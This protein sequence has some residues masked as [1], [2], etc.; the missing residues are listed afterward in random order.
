MKPLVSVI[1]PVYNT[2]RY[3]DKCIESVLA[4]TVQ[5]LEIILVDDGATDNSPRLCDEWAKKES[6]IQVIHKQNEGLGYTRNA[7][8]KVAMGEYVSFLD[9]DDT[10]DRDTYEK[11]IRRM[12]ELGADACYFGRKTMDAQGNMHLNTNIPEQLV[13][14]GRDVSAEFAKR[15]FGYFPIEESK[16]PYIQASACC[17]LYRRGIIE[18]NGL[19]FCSEREYLSEDSFFN[20]DF[21]KN[22]SCVCIF[23]EDFYNYTFNPNSLTKKR[24]K[25]KLNRIKKMYIKMEEYAEKFPE[26]EDSKE[27]VKALFF[28]YTRFFMINEIAAAKAEGIRELYRTVKELC[29]DTMIR[30]VYEKLPTACLNR[31]SKIYKNWVMHKRILLLMFYYGVV[32]K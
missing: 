21:C 5:E 27:R 12:Q 31:N 17:V 19:C 30:E 4:Q 23:P 25:D 29:E 14:R 3:L 22:A 18:K 1:I 20:L 28:G 7:G 8:L 10:L 6:R 13:Y 32:K 11:C 24:N 26:I 9:S 15:Y 2:E 16:I